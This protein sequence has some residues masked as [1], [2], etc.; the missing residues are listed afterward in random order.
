MNSTPRTYLYLY[1]RED[2]KNV[3]FVVS[4]GYSCPKNSSPG[5]MDYIPIVYCICCL[6]YLRLKMNGV[7][8]IPMRC[9]ALHNGNILL[10]CLSLLHCNVRN[11][12][13][14][15]SSAS[16]IT[17]F[18]EVTWFMM[19]TRSHTI[20]SVSWW[21]RWWRSVT[22]SVWRPSATTCGP[23]MASWYH[24]SIQC[25]R[26]SRPS[27]YSR[28]SCC[29][30]CIPLRLTTSPPMLSHPWCAGDGYGRE[31]DGEHGTLLGGRSASTRVGAAMVYPC[32]Q[33]FGMWKE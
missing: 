31:L 22:W 23:T 9:Q 7:Y 16:N 5:P 32:E 29:T 11:L 3:L 20:S 19:T 27:S 4:V 15:I 28:S 1:W 21:T 2:Y 8:R 6:D 25:D 12:N 17:G 33:R 26:A 14:S 24:V 10:S 13:L 18:M 30:S